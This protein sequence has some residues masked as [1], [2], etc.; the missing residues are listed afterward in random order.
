MRDFKKLAVWE[1]AHQAALST[2]EATTSFPP[3][4]QYGLT[5]Q[6]RRAASSIPT[7]IAEGCGRDS[8]AELARF[9]RIAMGSGNEVEYLL[10]LSRDLSYLNESTFNDLTARILET[11]RML[12]GF[13]KRLRSPSLEPE[14]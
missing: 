11:K 8:D 5:S 6:L 12:A 10:I 2:Y 14:A 13:L 7:N 3:F 4:E 9:L 1:K